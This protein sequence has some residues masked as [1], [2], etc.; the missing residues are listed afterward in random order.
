MDCKNLTDRYYSH[1]IGEPD[2]LVR[3][4][5]GVS[6]I[7]SCERNTAQY[8]YSKPFNLYAFVQKSRVVISYGDRIAA[9]IPELQKQIR[10]PLPAN[11]LMKLLADFFDTPISHNVKYRFDRLPDLAAHSRRLELNDY[12]AYLEFF[13]TAHPGSRTDWLEDYFTKLVASGCCGYFVDSKLVCAS[14]A[15]GMPYLESLVQEIGIYTLDGWRRR[16]F[17]SDVCISTA[18]A[19]I[20]SDRAPL[21]STSYDNIASQRLAEG[22]G[23]ARYADVLTLTLE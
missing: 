21:W 17:A 12:P 13:L 8:G 23:F 7:Y 11:Q 19:I 1:F 10:T 2:I 16:G 14:D 15:P 22:I 9:A 3:I 18:R 5:D 20:E 4:P 6:Y